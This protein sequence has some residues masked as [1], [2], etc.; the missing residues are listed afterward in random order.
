VKLIILGAGVGLESIGESVSRPKCLSPVGGGKRVLDVIIDCADKVGI[1]EIAFVGGD[2]LTEVMAAY[3]SLRYFFARNSDVKGNLHSL[4]SAASFLDTDT[5]VIYGDVLFDSSLFGL[6]ASGGSGATFV[7]DSLWATRFE[8][9]NKTLQ[10]EAE[11]VFRIG[12][13]FLFSRIEQRV[14]PLGEFAGI[15][16]FRTHALSAFSEVLAELTKKDAQATIL[17]ALNHPRLNRLLASVDIKGHWAELDSSQDINAF[18]FGTKADTLKN[19]M[20]KVSKCSI[21][22]Q[23][24]FT[25]SDWRGDDAHI[26]DRIQF[27]FAGAKSLVVRSSAISED[28]KNSSMAGNFKSILDV[29]ASN[30]D[31]IRKAISEVIDSYLEKEICEKEDNQVFV[32]PY[33]KNIDISGVAFTR[34]METKAPYFVINFDQ[35]TRRTDT[36]T[37]GGGEKLRTYVVNKFMRTTGLQWLDH[38]LEALREI[39]AV[40][41]NDFVDIEFAIRGSQTVLLQVRPIAAHKNELRVADSDF[42]K[43]I[44]SVKEYVSQH[45]GSSQVGLCGDR[46]AYGVMPDWNPAEII[47]VSPKPLALSLYKRLI[48]DDIWPESRASLGYHDVG[49]NFG[50]VSFAGRPYIDLRVS[51]NTLTPK[52]IEEGLASRLND[53][54]IGFLENNRHL[55]DKVEFDVAI[56]CYS[57]DVTRLKRHLEN[58]GFSSSECAEIIESFRIF[59]RNILKNGEKSISRMMQSLDTLEALNGHLKNQEICPYAKMHHL[60]ADCRKYGTFNFSQ[61]ARFAFIAANLMRSLVSTK[62]LSEER[63]HAFMETISTIPKMLIEDLGHMDHE[64]LISKYGHL[65]PGTYDVESMAYNEQHGIFGNVSNQ[66]PSESSVPEFSWTPNELRGIENSLERA[67]FDISVP[68]F[69][70]FIRSSIEAREFAKFIFTKSVSDILDSCVAIG[71]S[72]N[73][74]REDVSFLRI[75]DFLGV[76]GINLS[77]NI[78]NEWRNTISYNKKGFLLSHSLK[79]PALIFS[80]QD[81]DFHLHDSEEPNFI[82]NQ[83]CAAPIIQLDL[84]KGLPDEIIGKIVVIEKAD[85]GYDWIFTHN[86]VGLITKYGGIASH[87]SIRCAELSIPAGIG[88]GELIY[89]YVC[90]S[91]VIELD[92]SSRNIKRVS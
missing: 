36:V 68:A 73:I 26:L 9:R 14:N 17:D 13:G 55:H 44:K 16:L 38:L 92:C 10:A 5:L 52:D 83:K 76:H 43:T 27:E 29:D 39:E 41:G 33:L 77:F 37:S 50:M 35:T 40:A 80:E 88:C 54:Y 66:E 62:V 6:L 25:V 65:R 28:T 45:V 22:P 46:T 78:E 8:G 30:K 87:M 56:T 3:P 84:H 19:L 61:L 42:I 89:Q 51:F 57:F 53:F 64:S 86:I 11:K 2:N 21:L 12:E 90:H 47:G 63:L 32:Q 18:R 72:V 79:L 4:Y 74:R 49:N 67:G 31:L 24:S 59:T 69:I 60:V 23:L 82:T 85:P 20:D 91:S 71:R 48:T 70:Q 7:Y 75:D 34:D 15:V 81:V 58:G 1:S